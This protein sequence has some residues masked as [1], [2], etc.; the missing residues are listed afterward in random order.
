M[1][2]A[3]LEN[4]LPIP[5]YE[6]LYSISSH[7]RIRSEARIVRHY[8]GGQKLL[9]ERLRAI[10]PNMHGY[11]SVILSKEGRNTRF[12][13]HRLVLRAFVGEPPYG[14]DACHND[15]DRSN[16]KLENLRWDTRAGNMQ[17][18][19]NHGTRRRGESVH[20]HKITEQTA[21]AIR[22]DN[23]L[24]KE[25]ARDFQISQSAVSLIKRGKRWAYLSSRQ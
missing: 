4:W 14:V 1:G 8:S 15:G 6:G 20:F 18:T 11:A 19:I 5:G 2:K 17:D 7:G 16:N 21:L 12:T 13:V 10:C 25:I 3:D 24:H 23:R 22:R 9:N